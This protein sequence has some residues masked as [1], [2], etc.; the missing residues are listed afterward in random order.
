MSINDTTITF[1]TSVNELEPLTTSN[2]NVKAII[3]NIAPTIENEMQL[4]VNTKEE[5]DAIRKYTE[6]ML[7]EIDKKD[8]VSEID[9]KD[10]VSEKETAT[11]LAK[12]NIEKGLDSDGAVKDLIKDKDFTFLKETTNK[13]TRCG[14]SGEQISDMIA[15]I[16]DNLDINA[17]NLKNNFEYIQ[18]QV[19]YKTE[20]YLKKKK[21]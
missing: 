7:S 9:K 13:L 16:I 20:E 12:E 6:L 5:A 2:P 10:I 11:E 14:I 3:A 8:I 4:A 21:M 18:V 19:K 15:E 17:D 1:R